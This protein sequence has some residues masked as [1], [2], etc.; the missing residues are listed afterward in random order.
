M[1][2]QIL[3]VKQIDA[4]RVDADELD[5]LFVQAR[6]SSGLRAAKSVLNC[7]GSGKV[8]VAIST[9]SANGNREH[10]RR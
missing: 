8:P 5:A 9:R 3:G 2:R 4:R 10:V 6:T 1:A 7:S